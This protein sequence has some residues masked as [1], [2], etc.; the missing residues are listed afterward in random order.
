MLRYSSGRESKEINQ[1][2]PYKIKF[3]LVIVW[4]IRGSVARDEDKTSEIDK[5]PCFC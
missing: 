4:R 3:I 2:N 5:I 1:G